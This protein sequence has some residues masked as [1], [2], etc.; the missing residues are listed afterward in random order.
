MHGCTGPA[1]SRAGAKT[2]RLNSSGAA[3]TRIKLRGMRIDPGEIETVLRTTPGV[4]DAV[5]VLERGAA[6]Q[7]Q[8]IG[9]IT[10]AHGSSIASADILDSMRTRLPGLHDPVAPRPPRTASFVAERQAR[11][12]GIADAG[13]GPA[14]RGPGDATTIGP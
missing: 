14:R 8:L 9:Y 7:D 4:Q 5:V 11:P 6:G 12:E 1:I 13:I 10:T 2:A 3:T